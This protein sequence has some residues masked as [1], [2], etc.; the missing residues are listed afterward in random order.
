MDVWVWFDYGMPGSNHY[1]VMV[2]GKPYDHF[3]STK[4]LTWSEEGDI[5]D[6]YR[7]A[8]TCYV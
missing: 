2:D 8:L 4:R 1:T 5:A 6:G 7:E 3:C